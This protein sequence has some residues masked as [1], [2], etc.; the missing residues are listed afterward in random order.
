MRADE[1]GEG[2]QEWGV[3]REESVFRNEGSTQPSGV[4]VCVLGGI[5]HPCC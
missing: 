2:V 3:T 5:H 4:C 1:G